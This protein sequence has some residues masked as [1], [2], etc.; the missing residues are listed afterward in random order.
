MS[1]LARI[2]Q[3]PAC[4]TVFFIL[5]TPF[6]LA[7]EPSVAGAAA[8]LA[9]GSQPDPVA[10]SGR[11]AQAPEAARSYPVA[12]QAA[13]P[14]TQ[15]NSTQP[16]AAPAGQPAPAPQSGSAAQPAQPVVLASKATAEIARS[17]LLV[18]RGT[19]AD[20]A[21]QLTIRRLSDRSVIDSNDVTVSIDGKSVTVTHEKPGSYEVPANDLR[22][23]G[24]RDSAK[25]VDIVVAHDGIR[26][27]L[28]GKVAVA[29]APSGGGLLGNHKQ[30]MWW[31][32]NIVIVLVA[33][34]AI[35]RRKG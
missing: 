13:A 23:D 19:A 20:D 5:I 30:I 27:I 12:P 29:E 22:G 25:D 28:S 10:Q 11:D 3:A 33:A 4:S 1:P 15:A 6:V 18:V 17:A 7:A 34:I 31:I 21:L 2:G 32:L 35:S 26:E 9:P 16:A 14:T 24:S 8:R